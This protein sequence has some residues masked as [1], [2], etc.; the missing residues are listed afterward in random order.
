MATFIELIKTGKVKAAFYKKQAA[1]ED[2]KGEL[3]KICKLDITSSNIRVFHMIH[4]SAEKE[5]V[6]FITA[7]RELKVLL[8]E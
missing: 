1:L 4:N 2:V 8:L 3:S 6:T 7:C 5:L